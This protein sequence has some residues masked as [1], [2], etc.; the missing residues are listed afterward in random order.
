MSLRDSMM[1]RFAQLQQEQQQRDAAALEAART[2]PIPGLTGPTSQGQIPGQIPGQVG[3]APP[4]QPMQPPM[5]GNHMFNPVGPY[6]QQAV[7]LAGLLGGGQQQL[8]MPGM[9]QPVGGMRNNMLLGSKARMPFYRPV[10]K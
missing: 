5:M 10:G 3:M 4:Q 9:H 6:G 8:G 1:A 2:Q 7:Q